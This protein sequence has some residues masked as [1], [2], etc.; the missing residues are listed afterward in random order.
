[1]DFLKQRDFLTRTSTKSVVSKILLLLPQQ[2]SVLR[3]VDTLVSCQQ[4]FQSTIAHQSLNTRTIARV[5]SQERTVIGIVANV[6]TRTSASTFTASNTRKTVGHGSMQLPRSSTWDSFASLT[7]AKSCASRVHLAEQGV[8][9]VL[10]A[11]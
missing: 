10:A 9:S 2:K 1:M 11:F 6:C 8:A 3:P 4:I 7:G 5:W